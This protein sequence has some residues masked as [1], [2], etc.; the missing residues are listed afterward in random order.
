MVFGV[1]ESRSAISLLRNPS[2]S[3]QQD[4]ELARG[5]TGGIGLGGRAGTAWQPTDTGSAQPPTGDLGGRR[6]A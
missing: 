5:E 1:V 2:A 6:R 4:L 3:K